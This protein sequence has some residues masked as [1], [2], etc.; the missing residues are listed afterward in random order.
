M[1]FL[2]KILV[3]IP[4]AITADEY[5]SREEILSAVKNHARNE[6]ESFYEQAFDWRE[7]QSAG[8]WE[9]EY[10]QQ[11]YVASDD[12]EWF[13]KELAEVQTQQ[14]GEIDWAVAQL[15]SAVGIDL[16]HIVEGLW[17]RDGRNFDPTKS[18][19]ISCMAAFYL[20]NIADA[21]YGTYRCD[22]YF[23]NTHDYTARLYQS[24]LDMI[25]QEPENWALVMFDYHY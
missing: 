7:D 15:T 9:A 12:L 17:N 11:A 4:S 25:R 10:P 14:K 20:R 3:H 24:D 19:G 16:K 21:L 6:T 8:R 2:H 1:H 13:M 18:D 22:S 5:T 23:Y